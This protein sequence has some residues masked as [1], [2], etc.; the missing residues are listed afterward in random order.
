NE[1]AP[2]TERRES[3]VEVDVPIAEVHVV[4]FELPGPVTPSSIFETHA[5]HPAGSRVVVVVEDNTAVA[6]DR[7]IN[8][9]RMTV[10]PEPEAEVR[11]RKRTAA[12]V[13]EQPLTP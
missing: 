10:V 3:V 1:S 12:L 5:D 4:V 7:K 11:I 6:D 9:Q 2:L 13:L 8:R